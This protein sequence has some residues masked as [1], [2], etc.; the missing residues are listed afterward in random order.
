M[1]IIHIEV[2]A[3]LKSLMAKEPCTIENPPTTM[4]SMAIGLVANFMM[5]L[6][7]T[8]TEIPLRACSETVG[9]TKA[10][11]TMQMTAAYFRGKIPEVRNSRNR[12]RD[13]LS[14]SLI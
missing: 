9:D 4:G 8:K 11:L 1:E 6:L 10:R 3:H 14:S 5:A 7:S 13:R 2:N 12:C